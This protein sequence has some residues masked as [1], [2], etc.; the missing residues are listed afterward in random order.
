[1]KSAEPGELS[2]LRRVVSQDYQ[3]SDLETA[4]GHQQPVGLSL[5]GL[6]VAKGIEAGD[7]PAIH[8]ILRESNSPDSIRAAG[9]NGLS[10]F[11]GCQDVVQALLR[12][13]DVWS[14]ILVLQKLCSTPCEAVLSSVTQLLEDKSTAGDFGVEYRVSNL[15]AVVLSKQTS[16]PEKLHSIFQNWLERQRGYLQSSSD[17]EN[18]WT[19]LLFAEL[20]ERDSIEA[21]RELVKTDDDPF[22][23]LERHLKR[24][25]AL[26]LSGS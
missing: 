12:S 9:L 21:L 26:W 19:V 3:R 8:Q 17:S 18:Q 2:F 5:Y 11:D 24:I 14:R 25:E 16:L 23:E 6:L 13:E 7:L 4:F 15:A 1:M 10:N 22:R 20:G